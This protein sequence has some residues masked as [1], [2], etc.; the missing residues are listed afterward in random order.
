[1]NPHYSQTF[2][3][4]LIV[5][6]ATGGTI[7]GAPADGNP[8]VE[9]RPGA[10][11]GD[12]LLSAVP[13]L[14]AL[15]TIQYEQ[16]SSIGSEDMT[17][18][19]WLRLLAAADEKLADPAVSGVVVLHGTDTME[20][21]AYFLN[22]TLNSPKPVV[23]TGAMRPPHAPDP[24]GPANIINAVRLAASPKAAGQGTLVAMYGRFHAARDVAKSDTLSIDAF[25][26]PNTGPLGEMTDEGPRFLRAVSKAH[27]VTSR[28]NRIRPEALPRVEIVYGHAGQRRTMAD[29][30]FEAGAEG[31]VHAGVG[32]GNIHREALPAL[33]RAAAAGVAVA[34]SSRVGAGPVPPRDL[35]RRN[36]LVAASNLNPQK[37]RVLLQLALTFTNDAREIQTL[38]DTH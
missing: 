13:G 22:L 4:P 34:C 38:F 7:A 21:T 30:A 35:L 8:L 25:Q 11:A 12:A 20:E 33:A 3:L 15:A 1:M 28:F 32:M 9:Y 10:L 16:I 5:I 31:I 24:D 17:D 27:T 37:T 23:F 6:L 14:D 26:S 18:E 29:A 19:V 2:S 36:G